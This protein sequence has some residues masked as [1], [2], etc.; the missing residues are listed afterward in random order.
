MN[1]LITGAT[2]G[3][4]K[5]LALDY[6]NLDH[7]V[8]AVGR[9]GAA[10]EELQTRGI[11][12]G[13]LDLT[14]RDT[15]LEWFKTLPHM[16]LVILNAGNC[17]YIDLPAFDSESVIRVMR[18]NVDS[19]AISIEGTLPL[20][21]MSCDGHL[22]IVGSSAAYIPLPR[23]EAYGAS[24]AAVAYMANSLRIDL[25]KEGIPVSLIAPG[26]VKTPLT[27]L[28]DFDMPFRITTE[29]ASNAIQAG[30]KRRKAEIH[31]P[32]K[33]TFIMKLMS[34]LPTP[35]WTNLAQKLVK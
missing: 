8:W 2:S 30:I 6:H 21:R 33:F 32:K 34:W 29:E 17:E 23:A 11:Q 9:N 13:K 5:Q 10:L 27:D 22:A 20:L 16:D 12:T 1:I 7:T 3:I 35:I 4:G 19:L 24:K 15:C 18:A 25:K 14:E 26:F 28:N 31:F